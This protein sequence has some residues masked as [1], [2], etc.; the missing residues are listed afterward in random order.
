MLIATCRI[1]SRRYALIGCHDGGDGGGNRDVVV[2]LMPSPVVMTVV[3]MV[4]VCTSDD[5]M[6]VMVVV[7]VVSHQTA[8]GG[9]DVG[10]GVDSEVVRAGNCMARGEACGS[11]SAAH[12][13]RCCLLLLLLGTECGCVPL[14]NAMPWRVQPFCC[15]TKICQLP[16]GCTCGK[17]AA[18]PR[19]L[20]AADSY[21][22]W[23]QGGAVS[24]DMYS[25]ACGV[26]L[27]AALLQ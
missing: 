20:V 10:D 8:W 22:F 4:V 26:P 1:M 16:G 5:V 13:K 18:V 2:W 24:P 15:A 19:G 17:A 14:P 9:D 11:Y 23:L 3:V 21:F 25:W 27:D 12:R 7:V 6:M